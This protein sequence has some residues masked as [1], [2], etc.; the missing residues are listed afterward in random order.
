V[1]QEESPAAGSSVEGEDGPRVGRASIG[2]TLSQ[3]GFETSRRFGELVGSIGLEPRQFAVLRATG[4]A[5]GRSQQ[6]IAEMLHIP[7]S[8]MVSLVDQLQGSKLLERRPHPLDRRTYTLHLT[9]EGSALLQKGLE[10][11]TG[12]EQE[13]GLGFSAAETWAL[14]AMLARVASN[15][16]VDSW[17]LPDRG[18][19]VR[20]EPVT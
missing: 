9:D 1:D 14:L 11:A 7:P 8:T 19:G 12:F 3:L 4:D 16:G 10:L 20:P 18:S 13:I 6:A 17:S 15:L 2:F 5:G